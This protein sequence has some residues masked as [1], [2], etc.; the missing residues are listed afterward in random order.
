MHTTQHMPLAIRQMFR[1]FLE[2]VQ[3]RLYAS[4]MPRDSD[5]FIVRLERFFPDFYTPLLQLYGQHPDFASQL[6]NLGQRMVAAYVARPE[7]LRLLDIKRQ[8]IPDWFQHQSM[9]G[10]VC[11]TDRF[12]DTLKG[13][14]TRLDYLSELGISYLHLMPLLKTRPGPDDGGYAVQDYR[15][16]APALGTMRD[17]A[18]LATEL[19]ARYISLCIDLVLNHTAHEHE[20]AQRA[21]AGDPKYL[22]YYHTFPDRT[23]PD[24]YERT[25]AEIFPTFAP[26]NFTWVPEIAGGGRWVWTTFNS[27]QWDLNYRNPAVFCDMA[28]TMLFLAN[29]GIDILRLDAVPYLWKQPGTP[30]R[31]LP[32]AHLLLQAFRAVM[33]VVAPAVIFKAEAMVP[34]D[35]LVRYL[36][37]GAATGKACELAYHN[38]LMVQLWSTLATQDATLMT[39]TLQQ[40]PPTPPQANWI[41][42]VRNHD[43]IGWA[44]TDE[45]AAAVGMDG[46]QHRQFL[47][48]FYS[49]AIPGSFARGARFQPNPATGDTRISGT[50]AALAGLEAALEAND[51]HQIDLAIQRILLLASVS[52]AAGGIPLIYMGDELGLPNTHTFLD[53]PTKA[54]DNRWMHRPTMDWQQAAHRHDPQHPTGRI[55]AG[56][57]HLI[58]TRFDSAIFHGAASLQPLWSNNRHVFAL[59]RH[60]PTG[61][62]LLLANFHPSDQ[63]VAADVASAAGLTGPLRDLLDTTGQPLPI[64]AGRILLPPYATMWLTSSD[65]PP[66]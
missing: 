45:H 21:I 55:F 2:G 11:Y 58:E 13:L 9:L 22:A 61:H 46:P 39:H 17:L 59:V 42:Y 19:H 48:D 33:R 32:E 38:Q 56:L 20:W 8:I 53:A 62:I 4:S 36:G 35:E 57:R 15:A 16:V 63:T 23:E 54:A 50:T 1:A 49:G 64:T 27:Y 3:E 66:A 29:Q 51:P 37:V 40:M 10:Y 47:N 14:S 44:V 24:A 26:G 41:T 31:N 28:D 65:P 18:E 30:C 52:L 25:L 34:P 12:A 5:M 7:A 43:D 60:H 6:A